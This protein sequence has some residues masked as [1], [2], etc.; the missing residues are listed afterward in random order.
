[1]GSVNSSEVRESRPYNGKS[2]IDQG[3]NYLR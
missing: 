3:E 1:M 2:V